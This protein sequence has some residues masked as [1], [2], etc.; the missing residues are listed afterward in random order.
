MLLTFRGP[1]ALSDFRRLPLLQRCRATLPAIADLNATH[2]Y[3]VQLHSE[4]DFQQRA[5]LEKIL[6]VLERAAA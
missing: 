3:L 1:S 4:P 5:Q 2:L 6:A